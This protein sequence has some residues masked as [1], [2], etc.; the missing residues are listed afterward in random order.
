MRLKKDVEFQI[1]RAP[2]DCTP[3][4]TNLPRLQTLYHMAKWLRIISL[5]KEFI[6]VECLMHE[7]QV[8]AHN[9]PLDSDCS[10]VSQ[11][12]LPKN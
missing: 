11:A 7:G 12:R 2:F 9:K 1:F 8:N 3:E 5:R 10:R 6:V 4:V